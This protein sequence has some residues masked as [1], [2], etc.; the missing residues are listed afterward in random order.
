MASVVVLAIVAWYAFTRPI[1]TNSCTR[2]DQPPGAFPT[3]D[4]R[5]G[6]LAGEWYVNGTLYGYAAAEDAPI[7]ADA[8]CAAG[9]GDL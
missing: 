8:R 5:G 2:L 9:D 6:N 3:I 4:Y 7:Y 1:P